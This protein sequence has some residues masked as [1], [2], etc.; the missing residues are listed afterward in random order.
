MIPA[1]NSLKEIEVTEQP[2]LCHHMIR[3]TCNVVGE[4]DGLEAVKQAVYNILNT[5]RYRY[6]IF[7]WNYGVELQDLIGKS[8]DYVM[9][10]RSEEHTSELQSRI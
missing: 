4:C 1:V 3:E 5:E 10:E 8:M 9:V 7:S 2:S 6:I